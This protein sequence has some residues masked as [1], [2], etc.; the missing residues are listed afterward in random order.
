[1]EGVRNAPPRIRLRTVVLDGPDAHGLA[2]FYARLLGWEPTIEE[3]YWVL[4][5]DPAGGT[6]L[7]FQ[8][9]PLYVRPVW[10]ETEGRPQ[11]SIHLDFQVDDLAAASAHAIGCGAVPAPAEDQTLPGVAVFFDPAGHPF[12]L[13]T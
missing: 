1:M 4:M 12:C 11:K 3:P 8:T 13:F 5:R 9:E 6:G 2:A 7:S 10:P